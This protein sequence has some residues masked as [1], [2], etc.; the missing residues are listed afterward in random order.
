MMSYQEEIAVIIPAYN[1][2][3]KIYPLL[4]GLKEA[5]FAHIVVVD[6]GS[7]EECRRYFERIEKE[8]PC[9]VLRHH[10]NLGKGRALK[11]AFNGVL[12]TWPQCVG[13]VT[14]DS[15]GQH[16]PEDTVRCAKA[17]LE[18]PDSLVMGCRDFRKENIPTRNRLGNVLTCHVVRLLCG[19]RVSDTQTGLRGVSREHMKILMNT[20][21]ERFEYEMNMLLD[22]KDQNIPLTEVPID[23]I[24]IESNETSHFNPLRDSLRV[25]G[26]FLK[27]IA[28]SLSS[29]VIDILLFTLFINLLK[30]VTAACYIYLSTAGARILSSL[31][32]FTVN[33]NSVFKNRDRT[34]GVL[35]KYVVLC[36]AQL[37][38]SALGVKG[39]V[40][41]LGW[42]ETV[43]KMIVD[44][45]LFLA[46]FPLQREWVFR[47][48]KKIGSR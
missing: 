10:V 2:D 30:P 34:N 3:E 6:D 41:L 22:T 44:T 8:Y 18:H 46:S 48:K 15:D 38:V 17:L 29:F 31:F 35:L 39:L 4:E 33:K 40:T 26:V 13:A 16:T 11:T 42:N 32:N 9:L 45:L 12:N 5:G 19:V 14:V 47:K 1:P 7:R 25:Y 43:V 36:L 20:R 23:T 37:T 24:Y 28:A 21:G 27:F